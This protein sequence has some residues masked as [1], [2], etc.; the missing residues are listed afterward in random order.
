[1]HALCTALLN[2]KT[3]EIAA[4]GLV[5]RRNAEG[6]KLFFE[7]F[8]DDIEFGFQNRGMF[9]HVCKH[10]GCIFEIKHMA[11]LIQ[12]VEAY[13]LCRQKLFHISHVCFAAGKT[14]N[15]RTRESDF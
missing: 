12:L 13:D 4:S 8:V 2:K 11:K 7:A 9:F 5:P 3:H 14:C 1:M 6:S 10:T 15:P